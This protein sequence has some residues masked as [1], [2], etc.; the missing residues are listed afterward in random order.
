MARA[1]RDERDGSVALCLVSDRAMRAL[2]RRYRGKDAPTDVLS[3]PSDAP[4]G[5]IVI[6]VDSAARQAKEAGH[7]TGR[8][9]RILFLHGYL[10]LLGYDHETD[11]GVMRRLE[12]RLRRDLL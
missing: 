2:N 10:H 3:F 11:G 5:D 8:E 1:V 9:I 12:R 6:S 7:S 4:F